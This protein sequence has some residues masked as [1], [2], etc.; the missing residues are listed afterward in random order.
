MKTS[1]QA[2]KN[3]AGFTLVE[4]L[5]VIAIIGTLVGLLL[6]A[7]QA[8]REAARQSICNNNLKQIGLALAN[9]ESV[10]N[11]YPPARGLVEMKGNNYDYT[12]GV[13]LLPFL[14]FSPEYDLIRSVAAGGTNPRNNQ[15]S[16]GTTGKYKTFKCPSDDTAFK[17]T[18]A[19]N[20][21]INGGDTMVT[22]DSYAQGY[23]TCFRGPFQNVNLD[24]NGKVTSSNTS[25]G[26][27]VR[28]KDI[29]DGLSK[30]FAYI[31][32]ICIS[33]A[34]DP[35]G[36]S[37]QSL[38]AFSVA[39]WGSGTSRPADCMT[40]ATNWI[41]TLYPGN[42]TA[43]AYTA[44]ADWASQDG[45]IGAQNQRVYAMVPPNGGPGCTSGNSQ[46]AHQYL[47]VN[48]SSH[49]PGGAGAVMFDGRVVFVADDIDAGNPSNPPGAAVSGSTDPKSYRGESV[50]GVWGALSTHDR[51][52]QKSL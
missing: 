27:Y 42:G 41:G 44:G 50:W 16:N 22:S 11:R 12:T 25:Y 51:R 28:N 32:G 1:I 21:R 34:T 6:P 48:A 19:G 45:G 43:T 10:K 13:V 18:T 47:Y 5:V 20:Y 15:Y 35:A 37:I 2:R 49:H 4:L 3:R 38:S 8:A 14:E 39:N 29:M 23:K 52:E 7:V 40:A 31:E 36:G 24:A 9:Y 26:V 17:V 33:G 46:Y 30:T